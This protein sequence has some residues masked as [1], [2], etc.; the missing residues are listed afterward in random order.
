MY[1]NILLYYIPI[2]DLYTS[3]GIQQAEL[4]IPYHAST[5]CNR[6]KSRITLQQQASCDV[7]LMLFLIKA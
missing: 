1:H 2:N 4:K 7:T 5:V 3:S 6:L